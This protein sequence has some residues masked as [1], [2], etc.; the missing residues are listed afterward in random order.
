MSK[1]RA[2]AVFLL[3]NLVLW[4]AAK[5]VI[6]YLG[7]RVPIEPALFEKGVAFLVVVILACWAIPPLARALA[8][9]DNRGE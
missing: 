7:P 9:D 2:A 1:W 8:P 6:V 3:W 4:S 5:A